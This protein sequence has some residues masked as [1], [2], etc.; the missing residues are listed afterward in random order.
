MQ[1]ATPVE[2]LHGRSPRRCGVTADEIVI[3]PAFEGPPG[4]GNGG[5]TCGLASRLLPGGAEVTLRKPPP[6]GTRL[7]VGARDDALEIR[8]DGD[9]VAE[10]RAARLLARPPDPPSFDEAQ[11]AS[12]GFPGHAR[13]PFPR[14]VVCGTERSDP[15]AFRLFPGPLDSRPILA[16]V[17]YPPTLASTAG[18]VRPELAWAAL[19]C[20]AGWAA[21]WFGGPPG[22]IVLGRM[23]VRLEGPIPSDPLIVIGWLG[24]VQGR[25]L[26]AGSAL[27]TRTGSLLGRSTQTWITLDGTGGRR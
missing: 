16:A 21:A 25:K 7:L 18:S 15:Q 3:D 4:S 26:R 22:P 9:V 24:C 13:H 6:L 10:V 14:C 12:A 2:P 17:W 11:A 1:P 23:A 20:P 19:D 27:F 8:H 5:Y